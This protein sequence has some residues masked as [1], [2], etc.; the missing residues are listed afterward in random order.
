M[1][2]PTV[3]RIVPDEKR[4][5]F[6]HNI[7]KALRL[8]HC[9]MLAA[10]GA[11]D[12]SDE[13]KTQK[14]LA[15]LRALIGLG[16]SHLEG[17]NREIH[18]ALEARAP[19]TSANAADDHK[20]HE[21]AFAELESLMRAVEVAVPQ[22]REFAGR[23]L[24]RRYALFAADDMLHMNEE[25]TELLLVLHRVFSDEELHEIEERIVAAIAPA[26]M[27]AYMKLFMPAL[28]HGERVAL[29]VQLR[30]GVPPEAFD[31]VMADAVKP[32]IDIAD[33]EAA[34]SA[35]GLGKAA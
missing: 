23:A 31:A 15:E 4:H 28:N 26:K 2:N 18:A 6:Y 32:T 30:A 11:H 29:L 24:Y 25:E 5:N 35:L 14:L 27:M 8:G 19:G 3:N 20:H 10:I 1:S 17:E 16:R 13:A 12:F 34:V 22:R 33:Y 7:H 21:D 9:R